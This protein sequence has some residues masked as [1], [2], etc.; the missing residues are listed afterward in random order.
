M[1]LNIQVLAHTFMYL[2]TFS[3]LTLRHL[4]YFVSSLCI[5]SSYHVAAWLFNQVTTASFRS[6]SF[7]KRLPAKCS[8][9]GNR[10]KSDGARSG[11][12]GIIVTALTT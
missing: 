9:T 3:P 8:F 6:S 11:L 5:P 2:S 4:S 10:N 12:Y 7:A 1:K